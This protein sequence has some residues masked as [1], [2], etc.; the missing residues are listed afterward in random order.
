MITP[1]AQSTN[2]PQAITFEV[3]KQ[4]ISEESSGA[5]AAQLLELSRQ[6]E[7]IKNAMKEDSETGRVDVKV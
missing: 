1:V 2:I 3:L 5:Q 4:T 6:Q 7:T